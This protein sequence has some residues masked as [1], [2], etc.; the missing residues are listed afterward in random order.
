MKHRH[1]LPDGWKSL[2]L[3]DIARVST[4]GTPDRTRPEYWGGSIPWV[5]T[6]TIDF[7]VILEP[8]EYITQAG[9]E[10]SSAKIFPKGTLLIAM[11][12]QGA[13]RG[14][15]ALLGLD[16]AFNQ[17]C[18]AIT[19]TNGDNVRFLFHYLSHHYHHI[20]RLGQAGTQSNLNASLIRAIP[21]IQPPP[22]EQAAIVRITDAWDFA[23]AKTAALISAKRT[24]KKGL[25]QELLTGRRRFTRFGRSA[26]GKKMPEGWQKSHL[27]KLF[28]RIIRKAKEGSALEPM[29]ISATIGFVPQ[30]EKF[31]KVIAGAQAE[32]YIRL[33]NGEF[34]YNKGNSNAYPQGCIY[35]QTGHEEV[36]VPHVY[37]CFR[38][39]SKLVDADFYAHYFEQGLLNHQ[40]S[41]LINSGVRNNGLLN[42]GP[43]D[44]FQAE[45]FVPPLQEQK[46][47]ACLLSKA[48]EDIRLLDRALESL[49][50]EK[51]GLMQKLLT[52]QIR[53]KEARNGRA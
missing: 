22:K 15:V 17:A 2:A 9:L 29:S 38:P 35:R 44:F 3:G 46:H 1:R 48:D 42:L 51:R 40:L 50:I 45:L 33:K 47:I 28:Q 7:N 18:S 21:F 20:R 41:R 12:G 43:E 13:T 14:K 24:L 26:T 25:A 6:G 53:V 32:N 19:P 36:S 11:F 10:N 39:N 27:G 49:K 23:I 52:G 5:A 30:R 31:S 16:A 4:G 37:L 34:A 8:S